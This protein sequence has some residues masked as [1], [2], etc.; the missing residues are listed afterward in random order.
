[1]D[2]EHLWHYNDQ[3]MQ[4]MTAHGGSSSSSSSSSTSSNSSS[5]SSSST[6]SNGS[7]NNGNSEA[8]NSDSDFLSNLCNIA[9]HRLYRLVKW[10]KSLP[11]FKNISVR[12]TLN[13]WIQTHF[14]LCGR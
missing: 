3:E 11:L 10:C 5:S 1:M 14:I 13:I 6:S 12:C 9:D 2:V 8:T 7:N 4:K